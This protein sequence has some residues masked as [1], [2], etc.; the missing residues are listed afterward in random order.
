MQIHCDGSNFGIAVYSRLHYTPDNSSIS[1]IP[2]VLWELRRL[3]EG[4]NAP[5]NVI[6][7][8]ANMCFKSNFLC[9]NL[10][11]TLQISGSINALLFREAALGAEVR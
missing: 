2:S 5:D 1:N 6:L 9:R 4:P 8:E 11:E 3:F 10:L 7:V